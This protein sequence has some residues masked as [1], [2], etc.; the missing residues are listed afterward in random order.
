[1]TAALVF[2]KFSFGAGFVRKAKTAN[3]IIK[4]KTQIAKTTA[5]AISLFSSLVNGRLVDPLAFTENPFLSSSTS[6]SFVKLYF[7]S[8]I[9]LV[10][11]LKRSNRQAVE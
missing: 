4:I 8:A 11:T 5:K 2:L 9:T 7:V 1:M 10:S 6:S 3:K